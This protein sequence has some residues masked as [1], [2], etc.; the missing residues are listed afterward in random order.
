MQAL[1]RWIETE[2]TEGRRRLF[3][4]IKKSHPKFTQASLTNYIQ[5][6]RIPNFDMA[7]IISQVT[8]IPILQLSFRFVHKP[9]SPN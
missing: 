8:G 9:D 2:G 4:A 5:G 7:Q 6:Q 1:N 3:Q